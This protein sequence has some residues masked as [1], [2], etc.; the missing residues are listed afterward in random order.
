MVRSKETNGMMS[1][2]PV[3]ISTNDSCPQWILHFY[4]ALKDPDG[5][6]TV[7]HWMLSISIL[8]SSKFFPLLKFV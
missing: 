5:M 2:I 8:H 7:V 3:L 4:K 6:F 1:G